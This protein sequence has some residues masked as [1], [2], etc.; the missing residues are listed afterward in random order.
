[1]MVNFHALA[2]YFKNTGGDFFLQTPRKGIKTS[3]FTSAL[4]LKDFSTTTLALAEY[5]Q[6]FSPADYFT[7]HRRMSDVIDDC[8]LDVLAAH[9]NLSLW[10]PHIYLKMANRITKLITQADTDTIEFFASNMHKIAAN[11]Y[12]MPKSDCVLF[13]IAV[14]FHTIKRYEEAIKYYKQAQFYIGE[15]FGLFYNIALCQH[16]LGLLT[17][18]LL[19]FENAIHLDATSKET[20]DWIIY[21]KKELAGKKM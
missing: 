2:N 21:L 6:G 7:L 9:M 15:Q 11:Y 20:Q 14:F 1:M 5:L 10:D 3:I 16:Q 12:Y 18:S 8:T 13:E 19:N 4:P 17:E